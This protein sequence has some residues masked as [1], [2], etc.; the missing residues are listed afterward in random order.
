M[1][2]TTIGGKAEAVVAR[3]LERKGY[4]ILAQNWKTKVC[5]ID[6]IANKDSVVYFVEVKYRQGAEQGSGLEHIT[7]QKLNRIK[8]A[9]RVWCHANNWDGDCRILG[10]EVSGMSYE[11]IELVEID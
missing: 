4:K 7:P 2:T 11:A 10:A 3:I 8:F 6:V 9:V 5:E 1:A